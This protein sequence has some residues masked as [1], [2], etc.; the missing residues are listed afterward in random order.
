MSQETSFIFVVDDDPRVREALSALLESAGLRVAAFASAA[1]FLE[2]EKPDCPSCLLLD[3]ELPD[4]NGLEVQQRLSDIDGPPIVFVTGHA[5]VPSSVRAMKSGAVEFLLKP[6]RKQD[7]MKAIADGLERDRL[8][9][10][11]RFAVAEMRRRY[12]LLTPREQE[13]LPLVVAGFANKQTAAELG[14]SEFTVAI[15]RGNIMRKMGARSLAEL[16]RMA[17]SLGIARRDLSPG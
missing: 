17:D 13:V 11:A 6:V 2:F 1:A 9:R 12:S 10:A 15:Q 7:L 8:A 5:D 3:L 16:I 4:I 14:N